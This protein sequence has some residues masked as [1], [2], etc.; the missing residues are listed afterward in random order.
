MFI[1]AFLA[2]IGLIPLFFWSWLIIL[3]PKHKIIGLKTPKLSFKSAQFLAKVILN[4]LLNIRL[5]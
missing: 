5:D 2:N 3:N 1:T 4:L